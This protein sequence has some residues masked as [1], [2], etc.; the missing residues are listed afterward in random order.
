MKMI[1]RDGRRASNR[2]RSGARRF[3][4]S[5]PETLPSRHP[6]VLWSCGP[7]VLWSCFR[8]PFLHHF[9]P[10]SALS[11]SSSL[12]HQPLTITN[13]TTRFRQVYAP[14]SYATTL[15]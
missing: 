14:R 12:A 8:E 9:A 3:G 6:A 13:C 1:E 11:F 7:V 10:F 4:N 15:L 5:K 2:E